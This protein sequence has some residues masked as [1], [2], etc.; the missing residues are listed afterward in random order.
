ML[1]D[2]HIHQNLHSKDSVL[3]IEEAVKEAKAL[4]L[5]GIGIT[6]H[7]DLGLKAKAQKISKELDFLI[8]VGVEIF[9]L[10][11]DLLCYG[12]N[13]MPKK[14]MSA[15]ETINFVHARGGICIAAHPYRHNNRGLGS[16]IES[17]EGLD[18]IEG[19]NGRTDQYSNRKAYDVAKLRN[20]PAT[21]S[22][23]AHRSGEVGNYVTEFDQPIMNEKDFIDAIKS[24]QFKPALLKETE[25]QLA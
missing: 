5:D 23:D 24:K 16:L 9:T 11:G 10:D 25:E 22:S 14:R 1:F 19:F 18:A 8:I 21:G 13:E 2:L 7:D 12:I 15:K 6:D 4:G 3:S 20:I 17:I